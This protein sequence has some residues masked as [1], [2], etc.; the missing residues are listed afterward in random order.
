MIY[1]YMINGKHCQHTSNAPIRGRWYLAFDPDAHTY[2]D[3]DGIVY[4]SCTRVVAG[5]HEPF[6]EEYWAVEMAASAEPPYAGMSPEEIIA[7]WKDTA[8]VGTWVHSVCQDVVDERGGNPRRLTDAER[9][10]YNHIRDE[11]RLWKY[12]K[13]CGYTQAE[14]IFW[15][16][17]YGVAGMFDIV[18]VDHDG[19]IIIDD[20]KTFRKATYDRIKKCG[21]QISIGCVLATELLGRDVLPGGVLLWE[22]YYEKRGESHLEYRPVADHRAEMQV[23]LKGYE[24]KTNYKRE[25]EML[26]LEETPKV[27]PMRAIIYGEPN[28]G[29]STLGAALPDPIVI[30]TEQSTDLIPRLNGRRLARPNTWPELLELLVDMRDSDPSKSLG[31][32]IA[33]LIID[34]IDWAEHQCGKETAKSKKKQFLNDIGYGKGDKLIADR[35]IELFELLREIQ[36]KHGWHIVLIAHATDQKAVDLV[37]GTRWQQR[38]LKL[39]PFARHIAVEWSNIMLFCHQERGTTTAPDDN[40]HIQATDAAGD[41]VIYTTTTDRFVAKNRHNLPPRIKMGYG[42]LLKAIFEPETAKEAGKKA[43]KTTAEKTNGGE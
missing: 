2:T 43:E 17:K 33:T 34:T 10:A 21:E 32:P 19:V 31:I 42:P 18:R 14:R 38:T 27:L 9:D 23:W 30:D 24:Y 4:E 1:A 11:F 36:E 22:N 5:L 12:G 15:S 35:F 13:A 37:D 39:T 6:E 20:I 8:A 3:S 16:Q 26:Q 28:V 25:C 40:G 7:Q 29:K 41:R